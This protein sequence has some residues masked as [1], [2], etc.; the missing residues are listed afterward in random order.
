MK[1]LNDIRDV[2]ASGVM[3]IAHDWLKLWLPRNKHFS[4]HSPLTAH[5]YQ[6]IGL[7]LHC[8]LSLG[9]PQLHADLDL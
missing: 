6:I 3:A 2:F 8:L 7:G 4:Q 1:T 5:P 9:C